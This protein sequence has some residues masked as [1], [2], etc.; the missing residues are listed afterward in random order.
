MNAT[1]SN[2]GGEVAGVFAWF[3]LAHTWHWLRVRA[4]TPPPGHAAACRAHITRLPSENGLLRNSP[5]LRNAST[6]GQTGA[7]ALTLMMM[8]GLAMGLLVIG[9]ADGVN[10][11]SAADQHNA[12]V[13][14][15]AR[16]A[17]IGYAATYRETHAGQVFGY[18][19]CPDNG[20]APSEGQA[21]SACGSTDVTVI[22]RLPWKTLDLPPLRDASGE[23][24]WY[25]VSGNYK[26]NPKTNDMLS[27]DTNGL[28]D[29]VA[30]DGSNFVAG[31]TAPRRAVAV[32][33]APGSIRKNQD[34]SF[35]VSSDPA[36]CGGNYDRRAYLDRDAVSNI[37]NGD[38]DKSANQITR[39]VAALDSDRT[40]DSDDA[41][42]DR[43]VTI[44][45]EDVFQ[46]HLHKRRDFEGY[47]TDPL[48]GLLREA[49]D[50]LVDYGRSNNAGQTHKYL[51]WA[52]SA[53]LITAWGDPSRY[54][55]TT[56]TLGGRLPRTAYKAASSSETNYSYNGVDAYGNPV[57]EYLLRQTSNECANWN[58][59]APFWNNWK[60]HF[61]YA[62][63]RAHS[64]TSSDADDTDPCASNECINVEGINGTI[65]YDVA[66]VVLFA[67]EKQASQS[68]NNVDTTIISADKG[69]PENYLEGANLVAIKNPPSSSSTPNRLFSKKDDAS[70]GFSND[71]IMC[72]RREPYGGSNSRLYVD[73]TCGASSQCQSDGPLLAAFKQASGTAN[74]CRVGSS[75]IDP[76]CQTLARKID[77]NNCPGSGSATYSCE[78]AA[79]DFL[80]EECL[81]GITSAM[82]IA[83][84]TALTNCQ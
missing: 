31:G 3:R 36:I 27:R 82:C 75:G 20:S 26:S 13:L 61:Y 29:V 69:K 8:L 47:L 65:T 1:G 57:D 63:A 10:S 50:C 6:S 19:P 64:V 84:Y 2:E 40:G 60:D 78:R 42:N 67:G 33:F 22:G 52:K 25:A 48:T 11:R 54:D 46:R 38:S 66:A 18:L 53:V 5:P 58:S 17:L 15:Q 74:N 7:A 37:D 21:A 9:Y 81:Q 71:T 72:I 83:A 59:V 56:G 79:R 70:N 35:D 76:A 30:A 34:R 49:A 62:L 44:T 12:R 45:P 4:C 28:I 16:E 51:P 73:P 80:S 39:Y 23:C 43:L 41:F 55:D 14:A 77:L 24:L 32:I 68:R